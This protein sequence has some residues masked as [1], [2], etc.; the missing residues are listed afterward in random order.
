[1]HSATELYVQGGKTMPVAHAPRMPKMVLSIPRSALGD[2]TTTI[3]IAQP[4]C[5]PKFVGAS[6]SPGCPPKHPHRRR[7]DRPDG[8]AGLHPP[9]TALP[10]PGAFWFVASK[11]PP[12]FATGS[13]PVYAGGGQ[14]FPVH[15]TRWLRISRAR[16]AERQISTSSP[17]GSLLTERVSPRVSTASV[18]GYLSPRRVT[19]VTR[20]SRGTRE[21]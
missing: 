16:P 19:P 6:L 9:R 8:A 5:R 7:S 3:F 1:M 11:W 14:G 2:L 18:S 21:R 4:P 17:S 12:P 13:V 15:Q 20:R 10:F